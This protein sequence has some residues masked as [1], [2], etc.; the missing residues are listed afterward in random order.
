MGSPIL[1]EVA[2]TNTLLPFEYRDELTPKHGD[3]IGCLDCLRLPLIVLE[4]MGS[5]DPLVAETHPD[6]YLFPGLKTL[7]SRIRLLI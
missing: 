1:L 3:V 5:K 2:S 7:V 4:E 6:G